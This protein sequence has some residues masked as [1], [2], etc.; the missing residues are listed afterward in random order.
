MN[1]T[2]VVRSAQVSNTRTKGSST[3]LTYVLCSYFPDWIGH[4][5]DWRVETLRKLA[6]LREIVAFLVSMLSMILG[7]LG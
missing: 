7:L 4:F 2:P 6:I 1:G 5:P 3:D